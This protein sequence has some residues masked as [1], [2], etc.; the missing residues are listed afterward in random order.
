MT[1]SFAYPLVLVLLLIP[2]YLIAWVWRRTDRQVVLPFDHV[3]ARKGRAW[4]F[5]ISL[6]ECLPPLL[7]AVAIFLLAGPQRLGD[8]QSRR[9]LTNIELVVD[10][11]GSMGA[12]FGDG[13]RYDAS[14]QAIDMFLGY[15]KG[16]A[17]GLT[18]F[19]DNVLHWVPLTTDSSAI[20]CAPPFMR[21]G[22][23]PPWM[24]GTMIAKALRASKKVLVERQEGDRM[25]VMVTDGDSFD[26]FLG[27]DYE[28]AKELKDANIT[29][30]SIHISDQPIPDAISNITGLTGGDAFQPE[31]AESLKH[32]FEK[33]DKMHQA[34]ME[35]K[36]GE[37]RDYFLPFCVAGVVMLGLFTLT[38]F[39]WRY[40]PW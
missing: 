34:P 31:N 35:R 7:L 2:T 36:L 38:Q 17:I 24:G 10:V 13:T 32:I 11:S 12:P 18:F 14:M 9:K 8:P 40:T 3:G 15:R 22:H 37:L 5:V 30:Y 19:G 39:G 6:A 16:D 29:V 28:I 23:T 20:K 25:I 33:I 4:W 26:L 1:F 21:P 27:G